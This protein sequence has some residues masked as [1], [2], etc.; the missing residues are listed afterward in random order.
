MAARPVDTFNR[1]GTLRGGGDIRDAQGLALGHD[2]SL[3]CKE[4]TT[5]SSVEMMATLAAMA[6]KAATAATAAMAVAAMPA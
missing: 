3:C 2:E 6:A 4:E 1:K 5:S